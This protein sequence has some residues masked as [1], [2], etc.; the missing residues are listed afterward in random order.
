[1]GTRGTPSDSLANLSGC[2]AR[3]LAEGEWTPLTTIGKR[4]MVFLAIADRP[5][6]TQTE[7]GRALNMSK[8]ATS[9]A[10][11]GLRRSVSWDNRRAR[12]G[13]DLIG[14]RFDPIETRARKIYLNERGEQVHKALRDAIEGKRVRL[15]AK[16]QAD[17]WRYDK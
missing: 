8:G 11:S 3:K 13:P 5:G 14:E 17:K 10:V 4:V 16:L 12:P 2:T 6:V 1:M 9:R 7:I 15:S